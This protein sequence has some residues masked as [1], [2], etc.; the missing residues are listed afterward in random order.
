M[1]KN[2][3]VPVWPFASFLTLEI[4]SFTCSFVFLRCHTFYISLSFPATR[5]NSFTLV[6]PLVATRRHSLYTWNFCNRPLSFTVTRCYTRYHSR[7]YSLTLDVPIKKI[8]A[9]FR[10]CS[11]IKKICVLYFDDVSHIYLLIN[12]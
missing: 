12:I 5:C 1:N 8:C 7:C 9:I 10:W 6:L 2:L 4:L 3:Q 11:P